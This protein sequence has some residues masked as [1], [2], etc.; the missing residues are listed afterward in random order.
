MR[1][2]LYISGTRADFGLL[3]STL[4]L[5]QQD[6]TLEV[7]VCVTGMHLASGY[8]NTVSEIEEAGL[9]ICGRIPV[10]LEDTTGASMARALADEL[11]G[12]IPVLEKEQPDLVL[13]LG[14]RGEMLAGALAAIHLNLPV[15]HIHGGERSGTVDEP[16]RH[17]ISKLAHYHF[18][19][20]E[21]SKKRLIKMGEVEDNIFITGAPGLDGLESMAQRSRD[22]LCSDLNLD[23]KAPVALVLFHPVLSEQGV[24]DQQ[25]VCLMDAVRQCEVQVVA[26]MPNSDAG[27]S[28]IR[29]ALDNYRDLDGVSL[30][31]HLPR[32]DFVSLMKH[33]DIMVGNSSSGIIEAATF[34]TPVINVGQRQQHRE[35]NANVTDVAVESQAIVQAVQKALQHGRLSEGNI[36]G[37][38]MAGKRI[39][40]LL[41][42]LPITADLLNKTNTY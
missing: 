35:R 36:Y 2:I 31:V 21:S 16:V 3:A 10:L 33:A 20:T 37:D 8:G 12:M 19:A 17:A 39:V 15:V 29:S 1:K 23:P 25:V 41:K 34:G 13:L 27:G 32:I 42:T 9:R 11:A 38:G 4:N 26:M 18:A 5:A 14:D 24:A 7:S 28:R 30:Q 22:D 6:S 40:D